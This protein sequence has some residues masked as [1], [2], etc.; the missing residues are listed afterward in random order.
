MYSTY[1]IHQF[2]LLHVCLV[3]LVPNFGTELVQEFCSNCCT[4]VFSPSSESFDGTQALF[5][6]IIKKLS[7]ENAGLYLS[8]CTDQQSAGD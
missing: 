4:S 2:S 8:D 1:V 3:L 7:N 6:L 5:L